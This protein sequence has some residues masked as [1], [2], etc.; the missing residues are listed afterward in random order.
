MAVPFADLAACKTGSHL[1]DP[2]TLML[3]PAMIHCPI[4]WTTMEFATW[5][6][7]NKHRANARR[8]R[9]DTFS[10]ATQAITQMGKL[11]VA[12]AACKRGFHLEDPV[13]QMMHLV[14]M[15]CPI[16]WTTMGFAT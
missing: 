2:V 7:L 3:R 9:K 12:L 16:A 13:T 10:S 1:E 6:R 15:R 11:F 4:A 8:L 14:T 5:I